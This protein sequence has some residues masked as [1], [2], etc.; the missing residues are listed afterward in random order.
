MRGWHSHNEERVPEEDES[1]TPA[2]E[3][4]ALEVD[5]GGVRHGGAAWW[6][7]MQHCG[8]A[9]EVTRLG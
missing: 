2:R 5:E 4:G 6:L 7:V 8:I 1:G 3:G 9:A